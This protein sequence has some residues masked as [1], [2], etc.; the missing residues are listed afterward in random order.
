MMGSVDLQTLFIIAVLLLIAGAAT[1][2][3]A[4]LFGVGGGA[5]SVPVLFETFSF[6]QL[7]DEVRMPLAVGTSLA[8]IIP[9]S[10]RSVRG[11][12][13]HGAVDLSV[14]R[15]WAAPILAGVVI[16][17]FIARYADP[18][19]FKVVFIG[20][21]GLVSVR[22]LRGAGWR[23]SEEMPGKPVMSIYGL[24][25]GL[26]SSLMGIGG[27]AL[28]NLVLSLYSTPIHRA[29]A[30]SSG[31]GV[32]IAVPG[33]IGYILAGWGKPGLPFD[34]LGYVSLL[35][36]ILLLPTSMLTTRLGVRIAHRLEKRKLEVLFGLFLLAVCL[37]FVYA[38][39]FG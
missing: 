26:L 29:V 37:R 22:M 1:G 11:H 35:G 30:T 10:I 32:L 25:I 33:T 9:T 7:A 14:L 13:K 39:A 6:M 3:L 31:V 18:W 34:A 23:V 19:I 5:V 17:S 36:L 38:V 16:G 12:F 24:V 8:L 15:T 28:S 4:G 27:G 21:A 2:F 20:V